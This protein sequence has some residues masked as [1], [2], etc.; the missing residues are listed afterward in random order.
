MIFWTSGWRTTS[1]SLN[2]MK[3]I[4]GREMRIFM[5]WRTPDLRGWGRSIWVMS[6][7]MTSFESKPARVRIIFICSRVVFW[8][9]SRMMKAP[10]RVRPRMKASGAISMT[11]RSIR[12]LAWSYWERSNRAS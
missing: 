8:A 6:A 5:A 9:S 12:R 7:V 11:P 1:L 10:L 3:A 4:S 2:W